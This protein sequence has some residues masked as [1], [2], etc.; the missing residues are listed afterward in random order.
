M[1]DYNNDAPDSYYEP[2]DYDDRDDDE[3]H[4]GEQAIETNIDIARDK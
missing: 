2:E 3:I 1:H 4:A